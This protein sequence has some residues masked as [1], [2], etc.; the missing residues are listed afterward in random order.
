MDDDIDDDVL[1]LKELHFYQFEEGPTVFLF[2]GVGRVC[3]GNVEREEE[4]ND[5]TMTRQ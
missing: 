4:D 3:N 2:A 1:W 5:T